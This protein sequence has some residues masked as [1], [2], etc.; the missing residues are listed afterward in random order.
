MYAIRSYYE[1]FLGFLHV[2]VLAAP[3]DAVARRELDLLGHRTLGLLDVGADVDPP[4]VD[5]DPGGAPGVLA[6]D[7][8]GALLERDVGDLGDRDVAAV[9]YNFV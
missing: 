1:P 9:S 6:L 2:L 7:R 4:Q 5:V 8:G 3:D